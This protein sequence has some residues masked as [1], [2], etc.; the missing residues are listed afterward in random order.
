[1]PFR[2]MEE[3]SPLNARLH[4]TNQAADHLADPDEYRD[5]LFLRSALPRLARNQLAAAAPYH[6]GHRPD[7]IR[8]GG[9]QP[10]VRARGG[11]EDAPHGGSSAAFGPADRGPRP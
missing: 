11:P 2:H 4:R 9:A 3:W 5:R 10:V 8:D 7:R 6:P 1:M